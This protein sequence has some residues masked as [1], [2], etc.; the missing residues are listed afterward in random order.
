MKKIAIIGG[1]DN[2]IAKKLLQENQI[3]AVIDLPNDITAKDL[4]NCIVRLESEQIKEK[5]R[6]TFRHLAKGEE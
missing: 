6:E 4:E 3:E 5:Y 2:L 1:I